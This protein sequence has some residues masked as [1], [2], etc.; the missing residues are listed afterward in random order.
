MLKSKSESVYRVR[1]AGTDHWIVY[2]DSFADPVASFPDKAAALAYAL[3]LARH[4]R[5][6]SEGAYALPGSRGAEVAEFG[7]QR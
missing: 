7:R 6:W 5:A 4:R 3:S 1:P 2:R